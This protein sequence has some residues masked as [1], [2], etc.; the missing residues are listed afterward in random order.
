MKADIKLSFFLPIIVTVI[1]II[2]TV[3]SLEYFD[4]IFIVGAIYIDVYYVVG[5]LKRKDALVINN[6]D[7]TIKS[8]FKVRSYEVSEL[9]ELS[10]IE[11]ESRI[12]AKYDSA[13]ITVCNDIYSISLEEIYNYLSTK[14]N[15]KA[16]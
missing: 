8:A 11:N 13:T 4:I 15:N 5:Y 6:L 3:L 2:V 16:N 9:S 7:I 14:S 10:Y 1:T 12:R